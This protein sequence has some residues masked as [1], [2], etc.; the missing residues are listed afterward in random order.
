MG[1]FRGPATTAKRA[2]GAC[3]PPS[4]PA[5]A[6]HP[7][8]ARSARRGRCLYPTYRRPTITRS[9]IMHST[10]IRYSSAS[11]M[12][13]VLSRRRFLKRFLCALAALGLFFGA[14]G[15]ARPDFIYWSDFVGG[16]IL[17]ANLDGTGVTTLVTGQSNPTW[18]G[19]DLAA[20]QM[21]WNNWGTR[22]LRRAN[23]DGSGQQILIPS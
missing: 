15:Q 21:Y 10:P 4:K 12:D 23:L 17:R 2:A 1:P 11:L 18:P 5:P 6:R 19:L 7:P 14:A 22:D 20:G 3:P 13:G 9:A 8:D 16:S